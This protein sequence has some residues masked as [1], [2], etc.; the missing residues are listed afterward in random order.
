MLCSQKK[1]ATRRPRL[2]GRPYGA[3][4]A[5]LSFD[6]WSTGLIGAIARN[7]FGAFA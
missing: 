3:F 5:E 6:L 2:P 4:L 1:D 7:D